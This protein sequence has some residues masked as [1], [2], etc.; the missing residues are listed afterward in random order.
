M[1]EWLPDGVVVVDQRGRIVYAN[2]QTERLTGYKRS[3][4]LGRPVEML[5]PVSLRA[6]H[7]GHR[8][9]YSA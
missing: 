3:E 6:I 8:L 4:L 7:R 9:A 2:R 5:L 1:L